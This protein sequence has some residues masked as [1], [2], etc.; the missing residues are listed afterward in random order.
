MK[1]FSTRFLVFSLLANAFISCSNPELE[2]ENT[3]LKEKI[4]QD[5][6]LL[7]SINAEMDVVYANLDSVSTLADSVQK[8]YTMLKLKKGNRKDNEL[9]VNAALNNMEDLQDNNR[10][11]LAQLQK[12]L[13]ES[14]AKNAPLLKMI[15]RLKKDIAQKDEQIAQLNQQLSNVSAELSQVRQNYI[16]EKKRAD[17]TENK[18][19]NTEV[20]VQKTKEQLAEEE[21]KRKE[22]ETKA[23][24]VWYAVG[25][26]ND[27]EKRGILQDKGGI[28]TKA[29]FDANVDNSKFIRIDQRQNTEVEVGAGIKPKKVKLLPERTADTYEFFDNS[30]TLYLRIKQPVKFWQV[31]K[32]LV[33]SY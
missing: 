16:A 20:E 23:N 11:L 1:I 25:K 33:I 30:G 28:F 24:S 3:Q 10:S 22:E 14:E 13:E 6:V 2:T 21:R 4:K 9:L 17:E 15:N 32:Y 8:L 26:E 5:S 12:K 18:L 31:S 27:L 19:A 29:T 7:V